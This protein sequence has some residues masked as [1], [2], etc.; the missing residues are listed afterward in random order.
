MYKAR[1]VCVSNDSSESNG[2]HCKTTRLWRTSSRRRVSTHTQVEMED[3]PKCLK[4]PKSECPDVWIRLPRHK[5]PKSWSNIEDPVVPLARKLYGHPLAVLLWERQFEEGH[6]QQGSFWDRTRGWHKN[7]WKE[8]ESGSHVEEMNETGRF[9]RTDIISWPRRLGCSSTWM[10][11]ELNFWKKKD[12]KNVR[13]NDFCWN[14]VTITR[15]GETS[16]KNRRVVQRHGRTC[17]KLRYKVSSPC[18]D[19]HQFK[20]ENS[21]QL[22]NS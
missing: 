10:Q 6:R 12:R 14:N 3:A 2:R 17:S 8:A 21:N 22:E 13:I 4:M 18:F 19:D 5:W 1:F 9:W 16:H 7:G 15:M 11:N 20:Q